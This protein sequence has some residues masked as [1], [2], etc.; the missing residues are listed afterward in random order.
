MYNKVDLDEYWLLN[1]MIFCLIPVQLRKP[2]LLVIF[3]NHEG[4]ELKILLDNK[5]LNK[6]NYNESKIELSTSDLK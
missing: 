3:I 5:I 1:V 6:I 4:L 2:T